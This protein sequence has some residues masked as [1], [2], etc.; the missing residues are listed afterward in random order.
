[1]HLFVEKHIVAAANQGRL[2]AGLVDG[3]V[4]QLVLHCAQLEQGRG[5]SQVAEEEEELMRGMRYVREDAE[6]T[7]NERGRGRL[8]VAKGFK[9]VWVHS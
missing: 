1:M 2:P 4:L 7:G 8:R 6:Q 3:L 5:R 9:F